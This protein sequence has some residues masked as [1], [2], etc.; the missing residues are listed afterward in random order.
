MKRQ[1][2]S[3]SAAT[4]VPDPPFDPIPC[5]MCGSI[6]MRIGQTVAV[7]TQEKLDDAGWLVAGRLK[8]FRCMH[9]QCGN[10]GYLAE[11]IRQQIP[12]SYRSIACPKCEQL[13][14]LTYAINRIDLETK[15]PSFTAR[16]LCTYCGKR[17]V[18][19]RL[20]STLKV[21]SIREVEFGFPFPKIKLAKSGA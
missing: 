12:I 20:V 16:I 1:R 2:A 8:L 11:T 9:G 14:H 19:S 10:C 7:T 17:S 18:F 6:G 21:W 3:T 13:D 4:P 5:P 15:P